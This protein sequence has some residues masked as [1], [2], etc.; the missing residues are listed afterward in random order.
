MTIPANLHTHTSFCDGENTAEEMIEQ[1]LA[2][3]FITLG[4]SSHADPPQGVPMDIPSYLNHIRSLQ[5]EYRGKLD[6]LCG[7]ELD[8]IMD[9]RFVAEGL[10]GSS[11]VPASGMGVEY[12]IGSTHNIPPA[13][14]AAWDHP[15]MMQD[16]RELCAA[17]MTGATCSSGSAA[18]SSVK[19]T[20]GN[21]VSPDP[22]PDCGFLCVDHTVQAM[23]ARCKEW[24]DGD[25]YAL[26]EDY[27]RFESTVVPRTRPAFI[28]HF[29]LVVRFN[30]LPSA[31]CGAFLDE[32]DPRYLRAAGS[33]AE[34]IV[35]DGLCYFEVNCGA[36]NRG[37][38]KEPYPS[39]GL[40][41]I[42]KE[43]DVELLVTSDAHHRDKL[44]SGFE[45]ALSQ[46]RSAGFDHI[47]VLTRHETDTPAVNTVQDTRFTNGRE[48][49]PLF[50]QRIPLTS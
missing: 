14:H 5:W 47:N 27:F 12:R 6:I 39:S 19:K 2:L 18:S 22:E 13:G 20:T 31:E 45:D 40:L 25:F 10:S 34:Q 43:L 32:R 4:F 1:A 44:A 33:A 50:W 21:T 49:V 3:Q 35:R 24:Y 8:N 30:D 37:R 46:I 41:R 36:I 26:A 9:P 28:G 42:L 16:A 15:L 23:H 17:Y 29:D 38:K 48:N 11:T 7:V